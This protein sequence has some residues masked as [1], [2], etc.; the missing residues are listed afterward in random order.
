MEVFIIR[1]LLGG[2]GVAIV[3]APLGCFIVWRRMAYFGDALSHSALLGV[4]LGIAVGF[5]LNLAI[6]GVFAV[7]AV[8]LSVL[9]G[10]RRVAMDTYLGIVAHGALSLGL[11]VISFLKSVRVD[12]M[13]YLFGDLLAVTVDDLIWIYAGG[14]LVLALTWWLW[15]GM[16]LMTVHEELAQAE[17]IP[18]FMIRLVFMGLMG[19]VTVIAMKIVGVVLITSLLIIPAAGARRLAKT[20]EQMALGAILLGMAAVAAGVVASMTWDTPSGPSIVIAAVL[21]FI[22]TSL[23]GLVRQTQRRHT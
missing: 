22:V 18:V 20:P 1:A 10:Q 2:I 3:A 13:G 11:V 9:Q 17:G 19:M 4:A 8:L 12:L 6:L 14:A 7:I 16:L 15:S 23:A 21:L 5:N